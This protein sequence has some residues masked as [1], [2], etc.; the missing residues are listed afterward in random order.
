[1]TCDYYLQ[2]T[3]RPQRSGEDGRWDLLKGG[4]FFRPPLP[5][6]ESPPDWA[7]FSTSGSPRVRREQSQASSWRLRLATPQRF[8]PTFFLPLELS[9]ISLVILNPLFYR[10][11]SVERTPP[12]RGRYPVRRRRRKGSVVSRRTAL[13][14][15]QPPFWQSSTISSGFFPFFR[16][17]RSDKRPEVGFPGRRCKDTPCFF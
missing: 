11:S 13:S 12:F 5:F 6:R 3:P 17:G 9:L 8:V 4:Y 15:I 2:L 16:V 1:L 14:L 10:V 7:F